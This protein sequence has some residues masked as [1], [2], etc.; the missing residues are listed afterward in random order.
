MRQW[1]WL[2]WLAAALWLA[3]PGFLFHVEI[4]RT[5][6]PG[7]VARFL[8]ALIPCVL[9]ALY[10]YCRLRRGG[11]WRWEFVALAAGPALVVFLR[12]PAAALA[13]GAVVLAAYALGS[14]VLRL[15]RLPVEGPLEEI[16]LSCAAGLGLLSLL[17]F[18]AG[19]ARLYHQWFFV[20]LS[21]GLLL[22]FQRSLFRL[23]NGLAGL[24]RA[25]A[26]SAELRS[27]FAGGAV[28]LAFPFLFVG[29]LT[30]LAPSVAFDSLKFHLSAVAS[31]LTHHALVVVPSVPESL[32]PQ[33]AEVLWTMAAGMGGQTAAQLLQ[34]A[35]L[36][37]MLLLLARTGR[38]CALGKVETVAGCL[39]AA[40][41]PFLHWTS[42]VVKND[43]LL[44]FYLLCALFGYL[45]WR[46]SGNFRWI[47]AAV[48]LTAMAFG[49]K[50][51]ALFGAV[52]LAPLLL[53]AVWKQP[54]RILAAA[55]LAG[56]FLILGLV[57]AGRAYAI[58]GN[59]VYPRSTGDVS[60]AGNPYVAKLPFHLRLLRVGY[61]LY[62]T[63]FRADHGFESVSPNAM[64]MLFVFYAPVWLLARRNRRRTP[65]E[66]A[67]LVFCGAYLVYWISL[68][69]VLRY[70]I[71][72]IALLGMLTTGRVFDFLGQSGRV[73][74]AA[75]GASLLY[76]VTLSLMAAIVLNVTVPQV[77]WFTGRLDR[78]E[79]LRRAL[80]TYPVLD[81]LRKH[82]RPGDLVFSLD[83]CSIAYAP[84]P[85]NFHCGFDLDFHKQPEI[86]AGVLTSRDHRYAILPLEPLGE[87][88]RTH[89]HPKLQF[90]QLYDDEYFG[91]Y[92]IRK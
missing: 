3:V 21:G 75:I 13:A 77:L 83:N 20:A 66:T 89:L 45:R 55:S 39:Y 80:I 52:A 33:G 28:L 40:T 88:I 68:I 16:P 23:W 62:W 30:A 41:F 57:W 72:P 67:A 5:H 48:F 91:L 14:W 11:L 74:R 51:V 35:I 81:E 2:A 76:C 53:H 65:A 37:V 34:P 29:I 43:T 56:I 24:H 15:A 84:E 70:A 49:V 69:F 61:A 25:W 6:S 18:A 47:Q 22:I 59:P 9:L 46:R 36:A 82:A 79:Y 87:Q 32:Y 38:E 86:A 1:L 60:D 4:L 85:E 90:E 78:H 8:P 26:A 73:V 44:A 12:S 17:L 7:I 64:G 19:Y 58:T 63:H 31:Y 50:H 27:A 71:A 10:A 54:R 92:R 42:F